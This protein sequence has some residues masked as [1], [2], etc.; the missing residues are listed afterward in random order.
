MLA[1]TILTLV[2]SQGCD[3][4]VVLSLFPWGWAL[5]AAGAAPFFLLSATGM[6]PPKIRAAQSLDDAGL[7]T[8]FTLS[9]G[10][11]TVSLDNG[12]P[13]ARVDFFKWVARGLIEGPQGFHIHPNGDIDINGKDIKLS[14]PRGTD[15][16]EK[17]INKRHDLPVSAPMAEPLAPPSPPPVA[18]SNKPEF[19]VH[20]DPLGH[21]LVVCVHGSER[22]E[23]G[24]RGLDHLIERGLITKPRHFHLDPLSRHVELDEAVF[25]SDEAGARALEAALNAKYAP[26]MHDDTELPVQITENQAS[27]TGFDIHFAAVLR[28]ARHELHEHLTQHSLDIL[29]DSAHCQI[30]HPGSVLRLSPPYL[31]ARR[32]GGVAGETRIP[33]LPDLQY[34]AASCAQ[35]QDFLNHPRLRLNARAA[36]ADSAASSGQPLQKIES[37][38]VVLNPQ[39]KMFLWIECAATGSKEPTGKA[40]THRN[41]AE[42]QHSGVFDENYDVILSFDNRNLSV[43]QKLTKTEERIT[44][45]HSSPEADLLR[46]GTMLTG[47]LSGKAS[48]PL[49]AVVSTSSAFEPANLA[50]A[51]TQAPSAGATLPQPA[52][53]ALAQN[54]EPLVPEEPVAVELEVSAPWLTVFDRIDNEKA[55]LE[56]FAR[57]VDLH[58]SGL[59]DAELSLDRVFSKRRFQILSFSH[60]AVTNAL[61]LRSAQFHGFYLS[62]INE[63]KTMLVYANAGRH[64]E[65]AP[66]KCLL[67]PAVSEDPRS[68]EGKALL[69]LAI[70]A[71]GT[72]GFVVSPECK[73]W[74]TPNESHYREARAAFL[75]PP[76]LAAEAEAYSIVW[77]AL[78]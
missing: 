15:K 72:F 51:Q 65:W 63:H 28:G 59:Q 5:G 42:W 6:A 3:P 29:Q 77:P 40:F 23:T 7:P 9:Y 69:G 21:I 52:D 20:L 67:Q 68:F 26:E 46:A 55:H 1:G 4:H 10:E 54:A 17:E 56:I 66:D 50:L 13:W 57:L 12:K 62:H 78:E 49:S 61:E 58:G 35:L 27:A 75:T 25:P 36:A 22:I 8:A 38:R 60:V 43:I 74:A 19:K 47:A 41:I 44:V 30:L 24:L 34:R 76:E 73:R 18:T 70:H 45:D 53:P 31:L 39:N 37:M 16:L 32:K 48:A 33:E 64:V 71:D 2:L 11:E 14:D